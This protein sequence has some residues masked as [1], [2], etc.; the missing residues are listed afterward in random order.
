MIVTEPSLTKIT[1]VL[2]FFAKHRIPW[3]A[4]KRFSRWQSDGHGLQHETSYIYFLE[5]A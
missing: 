1:I 5:K 3:K 2:Q 4:D